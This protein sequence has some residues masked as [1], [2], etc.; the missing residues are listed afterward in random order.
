MPEKKRKKTSCIFTSLFTGSFITAQA[1]APLKFQIHFFRG[2]AV[3]YRLL[4]SLSYS[5]GKPARWRLDVA[6]APAQPR[7]VHNQRQDLGSPL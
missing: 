5:I 1:L 7:R 6:L 2:N 3:I 4:K